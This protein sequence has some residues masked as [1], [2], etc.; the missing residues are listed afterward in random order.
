[1]AKK[2]TNKNNKKEA[3]EIFNSQVSKNPY[4]C[5]IPRDI[6]PPVIKNNI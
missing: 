2:K 1:M 5:P 4:I 3:K 6:L